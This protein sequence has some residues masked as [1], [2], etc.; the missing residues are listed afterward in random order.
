MKEKKFTI[1]MRF[2]AVLQ[3]NKNFTKVELWLAVIKQSPIQIKDLELLKGVNAAR[4]T[5]L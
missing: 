4:R 5:V 2:Y 3:N 1:Y